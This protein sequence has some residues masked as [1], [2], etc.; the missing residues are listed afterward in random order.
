MCDAF[1]IGK[2]L[3]ID[4]WGK[5]VGSLIQKL[6]NDCNYTGSD[7]NSLTETKKDINPDKKENSYSSQ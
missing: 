7:D 2:K 6:K 3:S 1:G 4:D 5:D